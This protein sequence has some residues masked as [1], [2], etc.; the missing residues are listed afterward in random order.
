MLFGGR[1]SVSPI[2]TKAKNTSRQQQPS[3]SPTK[4]Q[5][6][7]T[8]NNKTTNFNKSQ[9]KTK[10]TMGILYSLEEIYTQLNFNDFDAFAQERIIEARKNI[11]RLCAFFKDEPT[12][13]KHGDLLNLYC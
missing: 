7:K 8:D 3:K 11:E 5:G 2:S 9:L 10:E 12:C 6:F 4:K 1:S 13:P